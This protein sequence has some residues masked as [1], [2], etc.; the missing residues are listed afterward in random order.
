M[1]KI[2]LIIL[3]SM[4]AISCGNYD[5]GY[6]DGYY[7]TERRLILFGKNKYDQGYEDGSL[8]ADCGCWKRHNR[9]KYQKYCK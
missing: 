6:E 3:L 4:M 2:V 5:T 7:G 9:E 1:V 8:D